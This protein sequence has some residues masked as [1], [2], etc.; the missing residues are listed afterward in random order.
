MLPGGDAD[1]R[2]LALGEEAKKNPWWGCAGNDS[3]AL[4]ISGVFRERKFVHA[5]CNG[6]ALPLDQVSI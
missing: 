1:S 5:C 6:L 2:A 3:V 4:S